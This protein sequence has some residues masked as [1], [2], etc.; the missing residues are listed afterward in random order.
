MLRKLLQAAS[1]RLFPPSSPEE[2]EYRDAYRALDQA[3]RDAHQAGIYGTDTE[4]LAAARTRLGAAH[5]ALA[6]SRGE[7]VTEE[8]ALIVAIL[9]GERVDY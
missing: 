6:A 3:Q 8:T 4:E 1:D 2:R 7:E 9:R 5:D